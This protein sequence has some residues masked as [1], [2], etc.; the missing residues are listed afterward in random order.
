MF[1]HYTGVIKF[2][3]VLKLKKKAIT[4]GVMTTSIFFDRWNR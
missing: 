4:M 3:V 2:Y 1:V